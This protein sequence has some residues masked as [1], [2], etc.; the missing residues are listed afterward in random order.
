MSKNAEY[1][2]V[3]KLWTDA[4]YPLG[5]HTYS[6]PDLHKIPTG[7]YLQDIDRNEPVLRRLTPLDWKYFRYPFLREGNTV[8]KKKAVREHLQSKGY[9]I[10]EVTVDFEDWSWNDPYARC[11]NTGDL[12]AIK[13][14]KSTYLSNATDNLERAKKMT[15]ALFNKPVAHILLL[16]VGAFD[17]EMLE[18]LIRAYQDR[19]VEFIPVSEAVSDPIYELNPEVPFEFGAEFTFYVMKAR[20]LSLKDLGLEPYT[21]YPG[22]ELESKCR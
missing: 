8:S 3:V 19:G 2:A 5:N 7:N 6:H 4:G 14:L 21:G 1:N 13:W 12:N 11:K 16:H 17:A 18:P 10:A 15:D 20:K 22:A 9:R